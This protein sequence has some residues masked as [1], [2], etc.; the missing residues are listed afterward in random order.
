[1][2]KRPGTH[3]GELLGCRRA[4][5]PSSF[6]SID[7]IR[8]EDGKVAEHWGVTDTMTLMQQ[9]GAIPG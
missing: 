6:E 1:V 5:R 4:A 3:Q 7:I 2:G 8:L 9:I